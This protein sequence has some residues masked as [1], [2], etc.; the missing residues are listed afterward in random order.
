MHRFTLMHTKPLPFEH[1]TDLSRI[2][3]PRCGEL[4]TAAQSGVLSPDGKVHHA[5]RCEHCGEEFVTGAEMQA[6]YA[7]RGEPLTA[8]TKSKKSGIKKQLTTVVQQ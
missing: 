4:A 1:H 8:P 6:R 5:R 7:E 3:C 2:S